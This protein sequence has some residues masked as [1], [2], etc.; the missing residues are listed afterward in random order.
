MS[1]NRV[2]FL[3]LDGLGWNILRSVLD[4]GV[5]PFLKSCM[6]NSSKGTLLAIPPSTPPMWISIETGVKPER[7]GVL[8]HLLLLNNKVVPINSKYIKYP[9]I[10][11]ILNLEG[12][13]SLVINPVYETEI[14]RGRNVYI[15]SDRFVPTTGFWPRDFW[16]KFYHEYISYRDIFKVKPSFPIKRVKLEFITRMLIHNVNLIVN[17]M[18]KTDPFDLL[19]LELQEPDSLLHFD[20]NYVT[21]AKGQIGKLFNLIDK[22]IKRLYELY[23][24]VIIASDHGFKN[25]QY[26]INLVNL[27]QQHGLIKLT[28]HNQKVDNIF[29]KRLT[30]S[31]L[32]YIPPR[33]LMGIH[34]FL[35]KFLNSGL[36]IYLDLT[37]SKVLLSYWSLSFKPKFKAK[38]R[39][40][41]NGIPYFEEIKEINN[42]YILIP[43][44]KKGIGMLPAGR[45]HV[46]NSRAIIKGFTYHHPYGVFIALGESEMGRNLGIIHPH[47]IVPTIMDYMN[48][49]EPTHLDGISLL[50]ERR[51]KATRKNYYARY[52]IT[53][54]LKNLSEGVLMKKSP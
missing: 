54:R 36:P 21:K 26:M 5:T 31:I 2:A 53:K 38:L 19:W 17:L 25:I 34:M 6:N 30:S 16:R 39:S 29:S 32:A 9:K 23:D 12:K 24:L 45:V 48:L 44:Y 40:V 33:F 3:G 10:Y 11:D 43:F 18:D 4:K 1:K 8:D 50:S 13:K 28:S 27:L 42:N 47:D 7:H 15:F 37:R 46:L 22:L 52:I 41:L 51:E 14:K 20:F 49:P 35:N